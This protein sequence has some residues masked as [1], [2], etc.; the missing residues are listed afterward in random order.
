MKK[1]HKA[2]RK[3]DPSLLTAQGLEAPGSYFP[4][5]AG[6]IADSRPIATTQ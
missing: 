3:R 4:D 2:V 6:S 5:P 1:H